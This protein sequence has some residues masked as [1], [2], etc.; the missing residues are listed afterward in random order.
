MSVEIAMGTPLAEALNSAIRPKLVENGWASDGGD[1][2]LS[3]YILLMLVNGK[4]QSEIGTELATDLLGLD[5]EDETVGQFVQWLFGQIAAFNNSQGNN[6]SAPVSTSQEGFDSAM[7]QDMDSNA[8]DPLAELN[9]PTGPRS[10]RNGDVRGGRGKRI[11][12]QVNRAMDRTHESVLHRTRGN[13]RI[14]SHNRQPP[15]GPRGAGR[16]GNRGMNHRANNIAHGMAAQMQGMQGMP[17]MPGMNMGDPNFMMAA[18]AGANEQGQIFALLQQQNQMMAAL[19]QQL[20]DSQRQNHQMNGRGRGGRFDRND[21]GRGNNRRGGPHGGH[22]GRQED[23]AN[24]AGEGEDVD[25]GGERQ[26]NNPETVMCKFNLA[27]GNGNCKFAHQSPAAPPGITVDVT[28][29]CSYGAACKNFKCT[30]RHPSPATRRS[31]QSDQECKFYP[32]CTNPKCPFKHPEMP[33]CRNGGDCSVEGC[34]FTHLQTMCKFNPCTNRYCPYKHEDGQRGTFPDKVW[35]ANGSSNGHVSDRQ[36]TSNE[37]EERVL[38]GMDS[39][40][41][42]EEIA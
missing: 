39:A 8:L 34:K 3:E 38:P 9:V 17:G 32:H 5:P 6:G 19:S 41:M 4:T 1:A 22:H 42:D 7:D 11:L 23:S 10:M 36:F 13:D 37:A 25:M 15:S 35:T 30:A 12:G 24:G 14:N 29:V 18:G 2:P 27:C 28:D 26:A 20:A 21:R 33:A 31:H 16:M 40:V